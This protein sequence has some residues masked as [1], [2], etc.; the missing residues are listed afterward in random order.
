M[1]KSK[2]L[3]PALAVLALGMAAS[4]TGTVAWFTTNSKAFADQIAIKSQVPSA[5]FIKGTND[6]VIST[7]KDS[8]TDTEVHHGLGTPSHSL[9]PV[10]PNS[11]ALA[12]N[13]KLGLYP[14]STYSVQPTNTSSGTAATYDETHYL[15]GSKDD[16]NGNAVLTATGL[17]NYALWTRESIVRKGEAATTPAQYTLHADVTLSG[18]SENYA[19]R[20]VRVGFLTTKNNGDAWSWV[21]STRLAA[22]TSDETSLSFSQIDV[23]TA[24][25]DNSVL[26]IAVVI[27]IEGSDEN[28]TSSIFQVPYTWTFDI[29]YSATQTQAASNS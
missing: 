17:D 11:S 19:Y 21:E 16:T 10:H 15:T 12:S 14:A 27:W 29:Q 5:L 13:K 6:F 18:I 7:G 3:V 28:C 26:N 24:V 23:A 1:K 9:L 2:I 8:I 22:R 4:V 25:N 20:T